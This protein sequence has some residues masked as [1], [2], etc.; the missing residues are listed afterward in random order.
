MEDWQRVPGWALKGQLEI[1]RV[2]GCCWEQLGVLEGGVSCREQLEF[3]G[4]QVML[5]TVTVSI[6]FPGQPGRCET[7]E[8]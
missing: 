2:V 7:R 8:P 5:H 3:P 6:P 1:L 4:H